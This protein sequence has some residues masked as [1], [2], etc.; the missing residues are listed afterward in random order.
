M[1]KI[2]MLKGLPASGKSTYAKELVNRGNW[3]RVNKDDLRSM[4]HN[5]KWSKG[6]EK[7]VLRIRDSIIRE[8]LTGLNNSVVVDDTNFAPQHETALRAFADE[9]KIPFEVKFFDTDLE[10]CIKRDLK[11]PDSVGKDVIMKMY[12]QYLKPEPVVYAPDR[13]LPR[14][15]LVDIDGTIAHMNGR[16]PYDTTG[17]LND[18]Y[19]EDIG[20]I[21]ESM[22]L[23]NEIIFMSGRSSDYRDQ[24]IEWLANNGWP[25]NQLYMRASGDNRNDAIVKKELFE[26][27]IRDKYN[28]RFVL[29]DRDRVVNMWRNE[30][31]LKVLQVA[32]GDF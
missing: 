2:V 9:F 31:G 21:I 28:V 27:H 11:R 12:N 30:L 14:C 8:A 10:E 29:D 20:K 25:G 22:Q 24:T 23:Y 13:S 5:G 17:Y 6:N 16:G 1:S 3:V 7:M 32:E 26:E 18:T 4:L 19:D 15:I